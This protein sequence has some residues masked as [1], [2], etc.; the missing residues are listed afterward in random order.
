[1]NVTTIARTEGMRI[2]RLVLGPYETNAY[3]VI[4]GKTGESLLVDAPAETDKILRALEGTRP[5]SILMTHGHQD[6][7]GALVELK[8]VLMIPLG[9][10]SGD[11]SELP[12]PPDILLQDGDLVTVGALEL[13]VIHTPGHTPGSVCFFTAGHLLAGDT[14]FPG[15]PGHTRSPQDFRVIMSSLSARIFC[16]PEETLVH[17]GHGAGTTIGMEKGPFEAFR[18]RLGNRDL[19]GDVVWEALR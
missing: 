3:I 12:V 17:P 2:D 10:H 7:T 19:C 6:H 4:C 9:C 11:A 14:L 5:V 18:S 16:L 8:R 1:M 15:G 13:R